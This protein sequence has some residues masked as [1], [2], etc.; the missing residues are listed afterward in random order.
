MRG[1]TRLA[2]AFSKKL[3]NHRHAA[4]LFY[5]HYSFVRI[6]HILRVT[7]TLAVGISDHIW[8]TK[9]SRSSFLKTAHCRP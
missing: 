6:H 1:F 4:A 7:P 9:R 2:K 3:D 8:S 5:M